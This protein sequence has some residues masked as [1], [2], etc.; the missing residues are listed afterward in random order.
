MVSDTWNLR[1][2][3]LADISIILPLALAEQR[4]IAE[5]LDDLDEQITA[6]DALVKK[7]RQ[8]RVEAAD[9]FISDSSAHVTPLGD[10]LV[11]SPRNGYSPK[12][13]ED[14]TGI[15]ALG[16]G[17]LT[18]HGFAPIELKSVPNTRSAHQ[19]CTPR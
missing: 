8:M 12:G 6:A 9:S 11:E 5:I 7:L 4:W 19:V 16:L 18:H 2:S 10:L 15:V 14:W 17:C 3:F 1:F 13:A